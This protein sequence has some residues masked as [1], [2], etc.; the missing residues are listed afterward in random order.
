MQVKNKSGLTS[1]NVI[2]EN[3]NEQ[4]SPDMANGERNGE[5]ASVQS[6]NVANGPGNVSQQRDLFLNFT[7]KLVAH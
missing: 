3:I 6:E 5:E 7:I 4:Q 2:Y 1:P